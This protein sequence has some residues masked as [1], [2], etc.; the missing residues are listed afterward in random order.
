METQIK[1]YDIEL[2]THIYTSLY[3]HAALPIDIQKGYR[4]GIGISFIFSVDIEFAL[5]SCDTHD[6][7][8]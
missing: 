7:Q 1:N 6:T 2:I 5:S 4:R 3:L 8:L